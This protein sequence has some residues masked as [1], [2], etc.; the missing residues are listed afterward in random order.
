M[1]A[2]SQTAPGFRTVG[3]VVIGNA[4]EWYD[5][6]LYGF[7]AGTIGAQ[8]FPSAS[9]W[10]SLL[11]SF[12][13]FGSA[14]VVRPFG[15][16]ILAHLADQWGRRN[17]LV[18]VIAVMTVGTAMIAFVPG[19]AS[20]GLAGPIT[21]A[22]S[23]LLQG[24]AA[25]GEFASATAYLVE[26]AP[27]TRRGFY[28]AWQISGQGAAILL[29]GLAGSLTAQLMTPAQFESWGWRIPFLFGLLVG[30]VGYYLRVKLSEP[31]PFLEERARSSGGSAP[32]TSVLAAYKARVL[33][34]LGL[35]ISGSA[36]LYV[37]FVFMPTY[38]IRVIGLGTGSAF[39]APIVAGLTVAVL[40]PLTGLLSDAIGRKALLIVSTAGLL[41]APYPCFLWL[42]HERGVFALGLVEFAFGLLFAIGGGPF[43]AA[44]SEMF[45][46]RLRAT[47]LA[48]AYNFGVALFG[49]LA[50]LIVAW[51]IATTH[52]ALAP[53]YYVA[54]CGAVGLLAAALWPAPEPR[55]S[56]AA[57]TAG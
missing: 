22:V 10:T 45:P 32:L 26:A 34:G 46:V 17:V 49:G 33:I 9:P 36:S 1:T 13:V 20:I 38:A 40:C 42:Q 7:L 24:F 6:A 37:L 56:A 15:G 21:V 8:F 14:F 12:A 16:V 41:L 44:L 27:V 31:R 53:S 48:I 18:L 4:L 50:P 5:F 39:I 11:A 2:T 51:L 54:G 3:A 55:R 25:G 57:S 47:G 30:P 35:V 29:S 23:R 52:D 43:N 19:Y 28:G